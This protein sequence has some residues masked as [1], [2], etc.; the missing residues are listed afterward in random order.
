MWMI[1]H[2]VDKEAGDARGET[3]IGRVPRMC[4]W[5]HALPDDQE[6]LVKQPV[7]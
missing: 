3:R 1:V 6:M 4:L 2:I 5:A 7:L